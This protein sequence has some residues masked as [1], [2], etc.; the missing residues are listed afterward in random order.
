M[1][2]R[3]RN[4]AR[5]LLMSGTRYREQANDL[6]RAALVQERAAYYIEGLQQLPEA[7]ALERLRVAFEENPN[8]KAFDGAAKYEP[9]PE[10]KGGLS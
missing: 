6:E 7:E 3:L 2:I 8:L 9:L 4:I 1:N 10:P 5:R